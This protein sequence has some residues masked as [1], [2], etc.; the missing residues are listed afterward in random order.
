[1][2]D[3]GPVR[4]HRLRPGPWVGAPLKLGVSRQRQA[5]ALRRA[6]SGLSNED[7]TPHPIGIDAGSAV[8][9]EIADRGLDAE[10]SC[11]TES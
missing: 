4:G 11:G 8:V 7:G 1:M 3:Q 2:Q 5:G 10:A 9:A 6:G